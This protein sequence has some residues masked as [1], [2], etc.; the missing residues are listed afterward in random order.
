MSFQFRTQCWLMHKSSIFRLSQHQNIGTVNYLEHYQVVWISWR[1]QRYWLNKFNQEHKMNAVWNIPLKT[2]ISMSPKCLYIPKHW[3][4]KLNWVVHSQKITG[5]GNS[6][7]HDLLFFGRVHRAC[8]QGLWP[9]H[10][11]SYSLHHRRDYRQGSVE[12][13]HI[14]QTTNANS[15]L[16]LRLS[17]GIKR[18]DKPETQDNMIQSMKKLQGFWNWIGLAQRTV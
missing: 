8:V 4:V 17:E 1:H 2:T 16:Q 11:R 14:W 3:T 18:Q 5:S 9:L 6:L 13:P 7:A 12:K 10:S 15:D